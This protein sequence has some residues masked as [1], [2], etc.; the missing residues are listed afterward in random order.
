MA[1]SRRANGAESAEGFRDASRGERLQRVM[2]DAGIASRRDCER[3]IE[4]GLVEVNGTLVTDLPA[5]VDPAGDRIVVDGRVLPPPARA[6]YIL[7][8]KPTRT[9][10]S[11][12]DEPGSDRRTVLDLVQH[13]NSGQL[14]PVGRL[15]YDTTGL[16]LL[17]NDGE[18][19]NRLTHPRYGVPKV[20]RAAVKGRVDL[21]S[22]S[23]LEDGVK[24]TDRKDGRTV[25]A[26]KTGPVEVAVVHREADKTVLEVMIREGRNRQV[27]RM[28]AAMGYPVKKL[29]RIAMGPLRL[30]GVARGAWRELTRGEVQAL[31]RAAAQAART[32]SSDA[33]SR[34]GGS[35]RGG[36]RRG[37]SR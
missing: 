29:E 33:G 18:L 21:D 28:L 15:D 7:L 11:A 34:A 13:P 32:G 24:L 5:W 8:N 6:I 16:L 26:S 36:A 37:R 35:G 2:A 19:A 20:Y 17:T 31:R 27:R 9:L 1:R 4:E 25:G 23:G 22:I 30:K 10:T 12:R 14:F 3:M